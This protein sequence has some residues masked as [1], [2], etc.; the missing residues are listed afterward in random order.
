M[1]DSYEL[2]QARCRTPPHKACLFELIFINQI[3]E[4]EGK[5]TKRGRKGK[6]TKGKLNSWLAVGNWT[7]SH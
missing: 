4:I 3:E 2:I 5:E 1:I 6:P 7:Q